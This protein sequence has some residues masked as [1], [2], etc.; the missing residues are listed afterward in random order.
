MSFKSILFFQYWKSISQMIFNQ[1]QKL[2]QVQIEFFASIKFDT[3]SETE[4]TST[5]TTTTTLWMSRSY[6][7]NGREWNSL[8]RVFIHKKYVIWE[9]MRNRRW[10][11]EGRKAMMFCVVLISFRKVTKLPRLRRIRNSF[12]VMSMSVLISQIKFFAAASSR[13]W[14]IRAREEIKVWVLIERMRS[15]C[16]FD[17][18]MENFFFKRQKENNFFQVFRLKKKEFVALMSDLYSS[19]ALKSVS[20]RTVSLILTV[21]SLWSCFKLNLIFKLILESYL[22]KV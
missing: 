19:H 5:T 3:K 8:L 12:C 4:S 10:D 13:I 7:W 11:E 21:Q 6:E 15:E 1:H 17:K 20:R 14:V 18:K 16:P 9:E 22:L 2:I